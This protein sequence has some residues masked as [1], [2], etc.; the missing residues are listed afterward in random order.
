MRTRTGLPFSGCD[1][2]RLR[3]APIRNPKRPSGQV[4]SGMFWEPVPDQRSSDRRNG[5]RQDTGSS[6]SGPARQKAMSSD[7]RAAT[8]SEGASAPEGSG[9][10]GFRPGSCERGGTQG[11]GS[12]TVRRNQGFGQGSCR[13][14]CR[15]LRSMTTPMAGK[16][17]AS[18]ES[19]KRRTARASALTG[20]HRGH[21]KG[22]GPEGLRRTRDQDLSWLPALE[23]AHCERPASAEPDAKG[24][25]GP[26]A[27]PGP[28]TV[29]GPSRR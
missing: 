11:F 5:P 8:G 9:R 25:W 16:R 18:S 2:G 7:K 10:T 28:I 14:R 1:G 4:P 13:R 21:L 17:N 29:S 15:G 6:D 24:Q 19:A 22:F 3:E 23:T 20:S 27:M 26:A 12:W